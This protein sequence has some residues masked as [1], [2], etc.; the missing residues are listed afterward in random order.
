MSEIPEMLFNQL[1]EHHD[2]NVTSSTWN[3]NISGK[4]EPLPDYTGGT[5]VHGFKIV[6]SKHIVR[7]LVQSLNLLNKSEG[8]WASDH[9]I[10]GFSEPYRVYK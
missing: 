3:T 9:A 1:L 4:F 8:P 5:I 2:H 10:D 6:K 7:W